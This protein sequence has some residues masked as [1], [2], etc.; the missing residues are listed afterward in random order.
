MSTSRFCPTC[1]RIFADAEPAAG[2]TGEFA[3]PTAAALAAA[4]AEADPAAA[5]PAP[6][7]LPYAGADVC[8][9]CGKLAGQVKKL[10]T[11]PG[12]QICDECVK[13][14]VLILKDELGG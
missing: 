5:A 8:S 1:G 3:A 11:G 2:A 6:T 14:C 7:R 12:V 9:W 10:I 4:A 13:F